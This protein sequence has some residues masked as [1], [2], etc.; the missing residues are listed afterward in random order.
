M[1]ISA[2]DR[3]V[4]GD[5]EAASL[6]LDSLNRVLE[7]VEQGQADPLSLD[8]LAADYLAIATALQASGYELQSIELSGDTATVLVTAQDINLIELQMIQ[9]NEAWQIN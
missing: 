9:T 1:F 4:N 3:W 7:A 5:P 6:L 8:S 2:S